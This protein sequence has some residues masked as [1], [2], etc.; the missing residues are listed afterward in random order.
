MSGVLGSAAARI[1]AF[2]QRFL[3]EVVASAVTTACV[4][5]A[6]AA[7]LNYESLTTQE[8]DL[9]ALLAP[10]PE[11]GAV[12]FV[13]APKPAASPA[14]APAASPAAG[15]RKPA[16]GATVAAARKPVT[17]PARPKVETSAL[18]SG[19]PGRED[20]VLAAPLPDIEEPAFDVPSIDAHGR[21]LPFTTP[22]EGHVA[23]SGATPLDDQGKILGVKMAVDIPSGDDMVQGVRSLGSAVTSLIP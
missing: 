2:T 7:Y 9:S 5:G 14:A 13:W 10:H 19:I 15:K 1:G 21:A 16:A 11:K 23:A 4:A 12:A 20:D 17:P 6:T 3:S 18:H 22:V 8:P